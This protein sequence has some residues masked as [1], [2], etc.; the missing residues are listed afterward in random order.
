MGYS[1]LSEAEFARYVVL[2]AGNESAQGTEI[3]GCVRQP[4][5]DDSY[6]LH[7]VNSV[8]LGIYPM[9]S[10]P[11]GW[12]VRWGCIDLDVKSPTKRRWD[13]ETQDDAW[14]ASRN[15]EL[16]LA[17][18]DIHAWT[19]STKSGGFHVW[20]FTVT[21]V[22]A[23]TMR[24]ALLVACQLADVPPS[25]VNPKSEGFDDPLTL[26]N[27]VRLPY[28]GWDADRIERPMVDGTGD[29]ISLPEFIDTA[30]QQR[31]KLDTLETAASLW[32]AP[33]AAAPIERVPFS[34]TRIAAT[35]GTLSRRLQAVVTNGPLKKEDRS[36]WLYYVAR[37]CNEEGMSQNEAVNVLQLCDEAHTH[38]FTDRADG[39]RRLAETVGR[40]YQ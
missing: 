6:R 16:A 39:E 22:P 25:E 28:K 7:L 3:G 19:E 21:W 5:T 9:V 2:F 23:A 10:T 15:L 34:A 17:H 35:T 13:Y 1:H 14:I 26:G 27:Y 29:F 38:K 33:Q 20:V 31:A 4:V 36:G 24:R 12:F 8:P 40:A 37:L 30:W 32:V 18:L 11:E